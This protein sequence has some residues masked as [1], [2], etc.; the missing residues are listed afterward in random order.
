M[1]NTIDTISIDGKPC[2]WTV[3]F[4]YADSGKTETR[5]LTVPDDA[6]TVAATFAD[7]YPFMRVAVTE[8]PADRVKEMVQSRNKGK[9]LSL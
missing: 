7:M 5:K 8:S 1:N 3:T 9:G 6:S 2:D 4:N